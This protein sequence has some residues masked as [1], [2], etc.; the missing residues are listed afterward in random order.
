M[1]GKFIINLFLSIIIAFGFESSQVSFSESSSPETGRNEI[2]H[3]TNNGVEIIEPAGTTNE[4]RIV[5]PADLAGP[6]VLSKLSGP[7]LGQTPPDTIPKRFPPSSLLSDGIWWW[8]G[9]P[10]FSPDG[11]EMFFVKYISNKPRGNME[12]YWMKM[13]ED[14]EWTSPVH[15]SFASDSGDNSPVYADEGNRLLF[16]SYRDGS[17][18]IYQVTRADTGWSAPELVNMDYPSLP[19]NLGWDISLTPDQTMY[20]ELYVPGYWMDIYKSKLEEGEYS[21]F[22]KL[23]D[24]INSSS[25]DATPYIAAD[26]SYIIFMSNRSGGYG[27]H[28]LY[29]SFRN[30]DSTWTPA[31]NMGNQINGSSEDAMPLLSPDGLYL[32]FNSAKTG[33]LGYNAYWVKSSVIGK[34]NPFLLDTTQRIAFES[35]RDGD[36]EIYIMDNCGTSL[37]KMT[38]NYAEDRWPGFSQDGAKIA[39]CSNRDGNYEVYSMHGDG[40]NQLRLTNTP[41]QDELTPD[42]SPNRRKIIYVVSPIDNWM[43][44]EIHVMNSDGSGDTAITGNTN[45]DSRPI[46]SPDGNKILFYSKR[47]GHYEIYRM[48]PDGSG[49]E[50][51]TNS[52]TDKA[53]AQ[54]S[55][56]GAKIAYNTVDL[57]AM[58]GQVHVMNANGS[59]DTT[60]TDAPGFN[61]N[62]CWSPDGSKI[63]FQSNRSG[64]FEVYLMKADGSGQHDLTMNSSWDS[65]PSWG[66]KCSL[67]DAD[68]SGSID[69]GDVVYL[70]N[71]LFKNGPAPKPV[72]AGDGNNDN[73]VTVSDIVFLINYLFRG[74]PRPSC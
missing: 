62:P 57:V 49:Q 74:G 69:V 58:T 67:G 56:N 1:Y 66:R 59:S 31:V 3:Q 53:Y 38:S 63:A 7:Y 42:F 36:A 50:R 34:L 51:L 40:S 10:V 47:D 73:E 17:I 22:E 24:Q 41:N 64:N 16:T 72:T 61:E 65:W 71:Y 37:R 35:W 11:K 14:G 20:F 6:P 39:F 70:I 68:S 15:P 5:S 13:G 54:W 12:M 25:N 28:D 4:E 19:G 8:H 52:S 27:Y 32:F 30:A 44:S 48:N 26:E 18:K 43:V 60:L 23:P 2:W 29:V 45:G 21:Q 46:W 55:P 9:S 33:D